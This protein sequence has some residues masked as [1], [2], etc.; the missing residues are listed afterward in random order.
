MAGAERAVIRKQLVRR[1]RANCEC[2]KVPGVM[3][4]LADRL[5]IKSL[6]KRTRDDL[7]QH[8]LEAG[9]KRC[10]AWHTWLAAQRDT[11]DRK[12]F[13]W[14]RQEESSLPSSG[15]SEPQQLTTADAAWW[16]LW[17]GSLS[18]QEFGKAL[19]MVP[20]GPP[21]PSMRPITGKQLRRAALG[22]G[23]KAAGAD[24]LQTADWTRWP[25]EHWSK[26]SQLVI[27]AR[28]LA[29]GRSNS[30]LHTSCC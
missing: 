17:A 8:R 26:L 16:E 21:M 20:A 13:A 12:I 25:M 9:R 1:L 29:S 19:K 23:S 2:P 30:N 11:R 10:D 28:S 18:E 14:I 3:A 24:G 22:M 15:C 27:C 5:V 4:N 6:L 7:E